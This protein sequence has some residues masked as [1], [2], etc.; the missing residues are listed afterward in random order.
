MKD[1]P[2]DYASWDL[3]ELLEEARESIAWFLWQDEKRTTPVSPHDVMDIDV[4]NAGHAGI[5]VGTYQAALDVLDGLTEDDH[6]PSGDNFSIPEED[7]YT[8]NLA[9][10]V[11]LLCEAR[12]RYTDDAARLRIGIAVELLIGRP[13]DKR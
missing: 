10:T 13:R 3:E 11:R 6:G 5:R 2:D 12:S 7:A 1:L 8:R 4:T 9:R